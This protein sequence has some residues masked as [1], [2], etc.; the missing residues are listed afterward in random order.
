MQLPAAGAGV[1]FGWPDDVR[2]DPAAVKLAVLGL[3]GLSIHEAID[4]AWI[5]T[6][7]AANGVEGGEGRGVTPCHGAR[8][9][10]GGQ[11]PVSGLSFP[12]A[13]RMV[14]DRREPLHVDVF[15][16]QVE[17]RWACRFANPECACRTRDEFTAG[18]HFD[19]AAVAHDDGRPRVIPGRFLSCSRF[20]SKRRP[21]L[22][23]E[24]PHASI[25]H[26]AA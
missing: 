8:R 15:G 11:R 23:V 18:T 13:E 2:R 14:F 5:E 10:T 26:Q 12:L 9:I 24:F 17:R 7:P 20:L 1:A 25:S 3:Y 21:S 22:S 16:R 6:E 4:P 19:Q